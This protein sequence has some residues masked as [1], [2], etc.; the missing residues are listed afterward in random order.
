[1]EIAKQFFYSYINLIFK[2]SRHLAHLE[3]EFGGNLID[4]DLFFSFK[5]TRLISTLL[6]YLI[7]DALWHF[8][9][10]SE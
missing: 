7:K 8:D 4:A 6:P 2:F 9:F 5:C 1:M 10:L 3:S